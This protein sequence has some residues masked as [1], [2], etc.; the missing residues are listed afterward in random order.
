MRLK[1]SDMTQYYTIREYS[2]Y[3]LDEETTQAPSHGL[4]LYLHKSV[5]LHHI[6]KY[7]G[8]KVEAINVIISKEN[9]QFNI[10]GLYKITKNIDG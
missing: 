4:M 3:Q 10:V 1:A 5:K 2:T 6:S 7:P 9:V 8:D